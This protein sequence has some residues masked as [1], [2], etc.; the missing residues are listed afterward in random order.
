[1][2][3]DLEIGVCSYRDPVK[4][5]ATLRSILANLGTDNFRLTVF[6]NP[7]GSDGAGEECAKVFADVS[8][9]G[10]GVFVF[11]AAPLNVGY[12]GAVNWFIHNLREAPYLLY[13]DNDIEVR[14]PRF[15]QVM[16]AALGHEEVGLVI[17]GAGHYGFWNGRYHE[18]LWNAGYF[19]MLKRSMLPALEKSD[20]AHGRTL[21]F[22]DAGKFDS[23]LGH[24]EEVDF[25]IRLRLAGYVLAAYPA[26]EVLHHET[27]T[28]SDDAL[29]RPGGRIHDGVVR[30]MNK[31][32]G[33]FCGNALKYSMT[34]YDPR[35][36]RYTDWPPCALY[37]E[38]WT[39]SQFAPA[40][41]AQPREVE[42]SAGKMDAVEVLKP[43]GPYKGR[44]I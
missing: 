13:S 24:H 12:A 40:W 17:P 15:D 22:A 5:D 42:T 31:W 30:W 1:M 28:K 27:A 11:H 8:S 7:S 39:L 32:N 29:H 18:C 43:T 38:R 35:A 25:M 10:P 34:E 21:S 20:F 3:F 33:Y 36:L 6:H 19:W 2:Q 14:T 23:R 26:M 16:M 37:L 44:A 41:N 9:A 4:L